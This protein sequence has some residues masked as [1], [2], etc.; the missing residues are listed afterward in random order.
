ME[1]GGAVELITVCGDRDVCLP[2]L[3]LIADERKRPRGKAELVFLFSA[4]DVIT[5]SAV[6]GVLPSDAEKESCFAAEDVVS[7]AKRH[8]HAVVLV[9]LDMPGIDGLN[10]AEALA[11]AGFSRN[12]ILLSWFYSQ[13]QRKIISSLEVSYCFTKPV[14]VNA[15]FKRV[16]ECAEHLSSFDECGVFCDGEMFLAETGGVVSYGDSE[17]SLRIRSRA[18]LLLHEIGVPA[19]LCGHEYIRE[20]VLMAVEM[21]E[22]YGKVTK[23]IYPAIASRYHKSSR[24]VEKAIRTALETAWIRG[25][26]DLL[27]DMFGFTVSVQKGKPTNSEFI[28]LLADRLKG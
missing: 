5:E 6:E 24:S 19:N 18:T 27:N 4:E 20:A 11:E 12:I 1:K 13:L 17:S 21:D 28:A 7:V 22:I 26:V 10:I 25:R 3:R 15:L 8:P 2:F 14:D 9:D 23:V 16:A